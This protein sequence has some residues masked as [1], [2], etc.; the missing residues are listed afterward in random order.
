M[1]VQRETEPVF[2]EL[3]SLGSVPM[4]SCGDARFSGVGFD[5]PT[6]GNELF[7]Q[8]VEVGHSSESEELRHPLG[9]LAPKT[10]LQR[11]AARR[12]LFGIPGSE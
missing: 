9:Y 10:F 7:A 1:F 11:G 2:H 6:F 12:L 4:R 8:I 3:G 5:L